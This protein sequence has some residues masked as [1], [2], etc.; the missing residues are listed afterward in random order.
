MPSSYTASARYTLQ[1]TGEGTN[2]WGTINNAGVVTLIDFNVNG[3]IAVS[4][5]GAT[6]LTTANGSTDQAR[7]AILNYTGSTAGTL[8]IPSVSKVYQVRA[9]TAAVTVTNGASSVTVEAGDIQT[10][11]TDGTTVWL[12]KVAN[13]GGTRLK[14]IGAPTADTDAATKKYVDDAEFSPTVPAFPAL[15][16]NGGRKLQAFPTETNVQWDLGWIEKSAGFAADRGYRYLVDTTAGN[17]TATL[18]T[19]C[20]DGDEIWFSDGGY[21]VSAGGWAINRLIIDPGSATIMGD[22][23]D[24]NCRVRGA[25]FGLAYQGGDFRVIS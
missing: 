22:S 11:I 19:T 9:A 8:T 6:T 2:V 18:P 23:A 21:N 12:G 20:Q 10:V 17:V 24:L 3:T 7:A 13:Y 15:P 4:A 5:S 16:G 1:E 25:T 14:N